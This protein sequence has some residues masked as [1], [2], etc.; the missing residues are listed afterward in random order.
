MPIDR[1]CEIC[2]A[3][4]RIPPSRAKKGEGRFCST[5]C[6]TRPGD[7][8]PNWKGGLVERSCLECGTIFSVKPSQP[9]HYCSNKCVRAT[10]ARA[11]TLKAREEKVE[12]KCE[13]CGA[14]VLLKRSHAQKDGRGSFCS[15]RC[16]AFAYS[17][18][19]RRERV[20]SRSASGRREDLGGLYVRSA[21]EAN[22]ARY[23][24][25]LQARRQ[26]KEWKYEAVTFEFTEIKR[27]SR[28]YTPD[29]T[30]TNTDGSIEHHEVKGWMDQKSATK[31]KRM[32]LYY[33]N[34]KIVLIDK[35]PYREVEAKCG[36]LISHWEFPPDLTAYRHAYYLKKKAERA[37]A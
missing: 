4:F 34:D 3:A 17:R 13:V 18:G 30:V 7:K 31:L 14:T 35:Q 28:F 8:N 32:A 37:N 25:W 15:Y 29:F 10:N 9:G 26:I 24:N 2:G 23:L 5:R 33:P 27:G 20:Y 22:W 11:H 19:A 16:M 12:R 36:A 1:Q 6:A 21:W